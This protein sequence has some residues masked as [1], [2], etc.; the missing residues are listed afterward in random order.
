MVKS[1]NDLQED[2]PEAGQ[3]GTERVN[4]NSFL[5]I[6]DF[7][8][9]QY[10]NNFD[11]KSR[12]SHLLE[13]MQQVEDEVKLWNEET[14]NF[15]ML[16]DQKHHSVK[17]FVEADIGDNLRANH[18]IHANNLGK[19]CFKWS[20]IL[21]LSSRDDIQGGELLFKHWDPPVRRD[22]NGRV[23]GDEKTSQPQWINEQGTLIIF[24]SIAEHGYRMVV[25]G[26]CDR[27]YINYAGEPWK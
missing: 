23:V 22:N 7:L 1:I 16:W 18:N 24:P 27:L 8:P 26:S 15:N 5:A 13:I 6:K 17:T 4:F 2:W 19:T 20:T 21:N 12:E 14:H 25:S 3:V 11:I 9:Q 10:L